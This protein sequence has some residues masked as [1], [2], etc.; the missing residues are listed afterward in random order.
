[1]LWMPA[2][3]AQNRSLSAKVRAK[4]SSRGSMNILPCDALRGAIR[5]L[6]WGNA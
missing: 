3:L 6:P 4:A 5:M 2:P 1:M